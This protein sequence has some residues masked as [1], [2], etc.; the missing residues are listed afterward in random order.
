MQTSS[1]WMHNSSFLIQNS[2]CLMQ[3]SS[4]LLTAVALLSPPALAAYLWLRRN[5]NIPWISLWWGLCCWWGLLVVCAHA[6][7]SRRAISSGTVDCTAANDCERI[8]KTCRRLIDQQTTGKTCRRLIDQQT[9]HLQPRQILWLSTKSSFFSTQSIILQ[10]R[11]HHL[12]YP[13]RHLFSPEQQRQ[14]GPVQSPAH[15]G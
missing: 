6:A 13:F 5:Q 4:F 3:C 8:S 1:F 12:L 2:S 15:Q 14:V 10:Y 9:T 7:R 11:I